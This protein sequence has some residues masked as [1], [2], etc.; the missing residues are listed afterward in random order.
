[1]LQELVDADLEEAVSALKQAGIEIGNERIFSIPGVNPFLLGV[2]FGF[3]IKAGGN[4]K[5][6]E[7]FLWVA[8]QLLSANSEFTRDFSRGVYSKDYSYSFNKA[9]SAAKK[10]AVDTALRKRRQRAVKKGIRALGGNVSK[11]D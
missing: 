10:S 2:N 6:E 8:E 3:I 4:D 9:L 11:K 5:R 1:M 7:S